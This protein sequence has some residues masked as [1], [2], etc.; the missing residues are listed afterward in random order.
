MATFNIQ[1]KNILIVGLGRSGLASINLAM[2]KQANI[3]VY[4]DNKN[5]LNEFA[6]TIGKNNK[7]LFILKKINKKTVKNLNLIVISPSFQFKKVFLH[8]LLNN[9]IPVISELEF[10]YHFCKAPIFA[11]TGTNG[12][13]TTSTL[14]NAVFSNVT[15]SYLLGNVGTPL[16]E[17]V[18]DIKKED[19]VVC[20]VS[21][22]QLEYTVKFKPKI[23]ALLNL[24][25]DH[26]SHHKSIE[27]YH[28]AKL[29]IFDNMSPSDYA[30]INYDD[31][32]AVE[33]TKNIKAKIFYY[34]LNQP[35][36]G[37]YVQNDIIKFTNGVTAFD[38]MHI[39][40]I[41]L[42]GEHNLSNILCVITMAL[43]CGISR[44]IIA[45][46]ICNF[47]SL[48]HRIEFVQITN[49]VTYINDS[50]ATNIE[51]TIV[52][53]KTLKDRNI[54]LLLGG[55]DKK[56]NFKKLFKHNF[57]FVKLV[58]CYGQTKRKIKH[59]AKKFNY[60][61]TMLKNLKEATKFAQTQAKV[62]DTIL[63]S[64]ACASF[65]EFKN[66]EERGKYFKSIISEIDNAK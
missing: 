16:S 55:S 27:N 22:Y 13:T 7:K 47:I 64:P 2:Q 42:I 21:S 29:K 36:L 28:K 43:L 63:L 45:Q 19:N 30:V 11:I 5:R 39:K 56:E 33:K 14:L 10:A 24:G 9:K 26:I 4:D 60:N 52:A 35:V 12:K 25:I 3:Y 40:D 18:L 6:E 44:Q 37:T 54:I 41:K 58:V 66:F 38:I 1:N 49:G 59:W 34:S 23:S 51:S 48:E 15:Q 32:T 62:G 61:C 50:K 65:D 8:Y 31:Y 57:Y 20:E 46:T 53:L 17:K